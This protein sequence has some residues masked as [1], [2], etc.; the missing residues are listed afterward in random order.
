MLYSKTLWV[1][2]LALWMTGSAWWHVCKIKQ[3][4]ADDAVAATDTTALESSPASFTPDRLTLSDGAGFQLSLPGN[5]SFARSGFVAN[6]STLGLVDGKS[7]LDSLTA[8]LKANPSRSLAITGYYTGDEANTTSFTN[9]GLARAEGVRQYLVQRGIP[10]TALSTQGTLVSGATGSGLTFTPA[11]DSLYGGIG[12]GF[13]GATAVSI[14]DTTGLAAAAATPAAPLPAT[15]AGLAAAEKYTSV[16]EP[17][18]L[19]FQLGETSYIKTDETVKFFAEAAKYLAA[20][21]DK[22]LL[23]TGHTDNSGDD[24]VNLRLSRER[25]NQVRARLRRSGIDQGQI[26]VDA[27]GESAPKVSNETREGRKANRRVSVVVQ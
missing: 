13:E 19:Y 7:P 8:Y 23:I 12:M 27:K 1:I 22:K 21:K 17:I 9:L 16:F 5:F 24:A 20:H 2:L 15:E 11:G 26:S 4:C 3:L 25:A 6:M 18:D 10:A 14:P